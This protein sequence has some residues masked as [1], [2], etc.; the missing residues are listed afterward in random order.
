MLPASTGCCESPGGRTPRTQKRLL[1][2]GSREG[3]VRDPSCT[4]L[5]QATIQPSML[6][7]LL[8]RLEA[9]YNIA[10]DTKAGVSPGLLEVPAIRS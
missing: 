6:V 5:K 10:C 1:M 9:S 2:E 3:D 7:K 4:A 8:S